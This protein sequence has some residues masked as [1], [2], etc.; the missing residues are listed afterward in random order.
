MEDAERL[1]RI[2]RIL[3]EIQELLDDGAVI[4]VEGMKD[5]FALNELGISGQI[6][7]ASHP[8]LL[9]LADDLSRKADTVI[10][11]TDWDPKG[12]EMA[13]KIFK[14]LRASGTKPNA[15]LRGRLKKLV[16]NEINDVENIDGYIKTLRHKVRR[17]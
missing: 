14:Y 2:E 13:N 5:R 10:I 6:I 9:R 17:C 1:E 8:P 12:N 16:Q 15:R 7:L 4:I 3:A 11:L